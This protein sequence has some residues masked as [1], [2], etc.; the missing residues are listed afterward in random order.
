[1]VSEAS[2]AP[3]RQRA[4]LKTAL[5]LTLGLL[6]LAIYLYVELALNVTLVSLYSSGLAA[7]IDDYRELGN[8]IEFIGRLISGFGLAL[9][10][11]LLLPRALLRKL[12]VS[13][14]QG[15]LLG[16][17]LLWLVS[18]PALKLA[19]EQLV[20]STTPQEKL[21]SV[22][23][24]LFREALDRELLA[25]D[26]AETLNE[27]VQ[28]PQQRALLVALLPSLALVSNAVD[29]TIEA[30]TE[31]MVVAMMER[32]QRAYFREQVFPTYQRAWSAYDN[33][34]N[35][36][37]KA[38][39]EAR[40]VRQRL[41]APGVMEAK[42][43]QLQTGI[44]QQLAEEWRLYQT[45]FDEVDE[46]VEPLVATFLPEFRQRTPRYRSSK[47]NRSC[48]DE[49]TSE[50]VR[51][52][53]YHQ[54][55]GFPRLDGVI[56]PDPDDWFAT[57]Y[58]FG[59]EIHLKVVF[60]HARERY[61]AQ[62]FPFDD[63]LDQDEF[64][65]QPSIQRLVVA[66]ARAQGYAVADDWQRSDFQAIRQLLQ[67]QAQQA[68][69][70][71]WLAY[72]QQSRFRFVDRTLD[73]GE[74]A[75]EPKVD[76]MHR[77]ILGA[78]YFKGYRRS[79][80]F[81]ALFARWAETEENANFVRMLTDAAAEAAF[82][83]GGLMYD[84]GVDAVRLSYVPPVA[85]VASFS[86]ILMLVGRFGG[87]VH[88]QAPLL[89]KGYFATIG[90]LAIIAVSAVGNSKNSYA[91]A[92]REF[93]Q[94]TVTLTAPEL[95]FATFLGGVIDAE[96]FLLNRVPT[97]GL[98][99]LNGF[100]DVAPQAGVGQQ[101][102]ARA[103]QL[104]DRLHQTLLAL[105]M[106]KKEIEHS[107][108]APFDFNLAVIKADERVGLYA[109]LNY[110]AEGRLSKV[111]IPNVLASDE[112]GFAIEQRWIYRPDALR[113]AYAVLNSYA[114]PDGWMA[115]REVGKTS[116]RQ[117]LER[118]TL[119]VLRDTRNRQLQ[120]VHEAYAQGHNNL[121]FVQRGRGSVYDCYQMPRL[122]IENMAQLAARQVI[123]GQR[124]FECRGE[125]F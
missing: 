16:F 50:W 18:V 53:E 46:Y 1:M 37:Q 84:L 107:A 125:L 10:I 115:M 76:G 120:R 95:A 75:R 49:I 101:I 78:L 25:F 56:F 124:K 73:Q 9:G 74:Y 122:T 81:D 113:D 48:R 13:E 34:W 14:T 55:Q 97:P 60:Q 111:S 117:E 17:V 68:I 77:E 98:K 103:A 79:L 61:L 3:R 5:V 87:V 22:R 54:A 30:Q 121:I 92:M 19:V 66:H 32:D 21:A 102:Y 85:I 104:D 31:A 2:A 82:S 51:L 94:Q 83:P 33:E 45:A 63:D 39:E 100:F 108:V 7:L 20:I 27:I 112:V 57:S 23:S 26:G 11:S 42:F 35:R 72:Q 64:V 15:R 96:R 59:R 99:A 40:A 91:N 114:K 38:Q 52:V 123:E 47:C 90:L 109:G 29:G 116:L 118:R 93:G 80:G 36:Y 4:G 8:H 86:A 41:T 88:R 12:P 28:N 24:L 67:S 62:R 119:L 89:G 44:D 106:L 110:D 70:A 6:G 43:N 58:V 65:A 69:D 71:V 105:M